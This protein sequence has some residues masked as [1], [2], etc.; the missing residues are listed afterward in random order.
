MEMI[1]R[2]W[3]L[4]AVAAAA[5]LYAAV[6]WE[7]AK[8]VAAALMIRAEK[9][10]RERLLATGEDKLRWVAETSYPYLPAAFRLVVSRELWVKVVQA[11]WDAGKRW[12][13]RQP[14]PA[15]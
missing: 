11:V 6:R 9:E 2:W 12:A 8:T 5:G 15:T 10:A 13:K 7:H 3:G 4:L 1:A 14:D